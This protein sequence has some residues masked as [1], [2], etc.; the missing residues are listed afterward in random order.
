MGGEL[1][2][3]DD[4]MVTR[5]AIVKSGVVVNV[6]MAD[7]P[8][9]LVRSWFAS[10]TAN[11]GD[12]HDGVTFTAP[13]PD[14]KA[15]AAAKLAEIDRKSGM[16]RLLRETLLAVAGANAPQVLRDYEAEAATHR[17]RLRVTL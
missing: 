5:Y 7:E 2:H 12:L 14:E 6:V 17:A 15:L 8:P 9:A 13:P 10:D 4:R 1:G 3:G 11:I 16:S